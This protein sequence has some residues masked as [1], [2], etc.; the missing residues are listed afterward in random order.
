MVRLVNT[1]GLCNLIAFAVGSV[2]FSSTRF[3]MNWVALLVLLSTASS[4]LSSVR[5]NQKEWW[6]NTVIYQIL[7]PSF[8]DSNNDGIGDLRGIIEKIDYLKELGVETLWLTPFYS[9]PNGDIGYDISNHTEV[10]KDFG[11]MEDFD[12]LVKLVHSKGMK[13]LVEF[14]PNH[15][16]NK[17]DWFIKS[18]QKIDPYTNYY[19]WKDGLNGKP[20]TPPNNWL[21]KRS[22]SMW[23]FHEHRQQYYLHQF[24]DE[25]P[26]LNYRSE[27]LVKE[28]DAILEFWLKRGVDGFGMDSVL[29]LYEHESFANEPRLPEAAGR[30]DSDPTAYDHIYTI[31]QPETYEMLYKWRTLVEKF[32]NQSADRQPRMIITEAYSPSLEKVAKYYGTGD[33][34]GTHLSVNY[35]IMNK[36]GATSNAKDLENVVNAYLKSLPSGKWSSWMVGGHSITRIAT[37]Y[38]PDLVDAMN[39]LTLLLPGTAVTFAGDELGMESPIL[40]YEDQR[41][42]EGYIFGKDNY[43]K[44]CRDGSRV[45]FQ[46]ND[47]ENAGFSKAKS[48]LPVHP[49]YWTVNAQAEKKT[50]PSHYSVYK[51]LTTLRATSGAVRM[52]DY[53]ISTPNNYVF[54]L[55]RTEGSTSVYLIINLNSRTETVDLSDCIE[56]GGDVAIFTSSVNSGLVS[57]KLNWTAKK[58]ITLRAQASVVIT[59]NHNSN[60]CKSSGLTILPGYLVSVLSI[61]C[62]VLTLKY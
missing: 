25:L 52:G 60:E 29:K 9:G 4:V 54:I 14:V 5:C 39:M 36:F 41:D 7:V 34:Q 10:G 6:K 46:W 50:K 13:I 42:P 56:N 35:E 17:H 27:D 47:Q 44:V 3:K 58:T 53:K 55:T 1:Y 8:K 49:N 48:W 45:P 51:D 19:V 43:L 23:K 2:I 21:S 24:L 59:R 57:G 20:G 11:T 28:M 37:R 62:I 31:D 40:R 26:D 16:S 30:P 15:S 32:G 12:Q 22:G 61:L 38:S 18:A 33:T